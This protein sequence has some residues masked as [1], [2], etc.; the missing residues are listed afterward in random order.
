[1]S[2]QNIRERELESIDTHTFDC[3]ET[4]HIYDYIRC[5]RFNIIFT[6]ME[7]GKMREVCGDG[8]EW[9][10]IEERMSEIET[11]TVLLENSLPSIQIIPCHQYAVCCPSN[12]FVF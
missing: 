12:S 6:H 9:T 1:M 5:M 7:R 2:V 8:H 4:T 10:K 3:K 11:P